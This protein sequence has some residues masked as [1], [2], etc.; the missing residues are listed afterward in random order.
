LHLPTSVFD[1]PIEPI[2]YFVHRRDKFLNLKLHCQLTQPYGKQ[3]GL[4]MGLM[5]I[6]PWAWM[7]RFRHKPEIAF[8]T[9]GHLG[10]PGSKA[11]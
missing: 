2:I 3:L 11:G 8:A 7:A 4:P 9:A 6:W 5:G 1:E 10:Q